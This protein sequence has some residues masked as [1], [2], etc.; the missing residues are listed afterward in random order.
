MSC[1]KC[2]KDTGEME[3][4][5]ENCRE[6][7]KKYPVKPGTPIQLPKRNDFTVAR[8]TPKRRTVSLEE[9]VK[10]LRKQVRILVVML[11]ISVLLAAALAYPAVKY[12]LEDHFLPGQN[13]SV[14]T[15]VETTGETEEP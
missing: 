12:M 9:Q 14:I 11:V 2:G 7:M 4:F 1:L 8:K 3:V 13:Y 6:E 5:C 10:T 15:V